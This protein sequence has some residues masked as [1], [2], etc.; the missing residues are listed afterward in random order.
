MTDLIETV[1]T[2]YDYSYEITKFPDEG[3]S[4]IISLYDIEGKRR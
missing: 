2:G 1:L 4:V 3:Y